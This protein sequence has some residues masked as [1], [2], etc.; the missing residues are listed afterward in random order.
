M[1]ER[2]IEVDLFDNPIKPLTKKEAH[3][4]RN[5]EVGNPHRAFSVFIFNQ[6]NELLL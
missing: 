5:L 6:N 2:I 4:N 3:L 1:E